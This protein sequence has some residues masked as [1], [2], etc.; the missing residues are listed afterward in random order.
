MTAICGTFPCGKPSLTPWVHKFSKGKNFILLTLVFLEQVQCLFR[1]HAVEVLMGLKTK[2]RERTPW[3]WGGGYAWGRVTTGTAYISH[4]WGPFFSDDRRSW[5]L[6]FFLSSWAICL[7]DSTSRA[8][9][10]KWNSNPSHLDFQQFWWRSW[11]GRSLETLSNMRFWCGLW[12]L[13]L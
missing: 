2:K 7:L 11:L 13:I 5:L 10:R 1:G 3:Q 12:I 8:K 6:L 4:W 9:R